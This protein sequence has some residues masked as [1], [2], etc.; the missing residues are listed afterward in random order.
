MEATKKIADAVQMMPGLYLLVRIKIPV[1]P[2]TPFITSNH[3]FICSKGQPKAMIVCFS[4]KL[5]SIYFIADLMAKRGYSLN[6]LQR[7]ACIHLCV[8][9]RTNADKFLADLND[10]LASIKV[11]SEAAKKTDGTAAIYGMAG[12][13]PAGPVNELLKVYNDVVLSC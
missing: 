7:P 4:S 6:S 11:D 5:Y 9:R 13:M 1:I 12:S 8:T 3:H 10:V 2:C